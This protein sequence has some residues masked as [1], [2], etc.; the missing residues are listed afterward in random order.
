MADIVER[1]YGGLDDTWWPNG[2]GVVDCFV[3]D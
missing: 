1:C 2:R 3:L